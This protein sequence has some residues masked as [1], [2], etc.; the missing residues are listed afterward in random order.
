MEVPHRDSED[1][2][3]KKNKTRNNNT[4]SLQLTRNSVGAKAVISTVGAPQPHRRSTTAAPLEHHSSI[5][6]APSVHCLRIGSRHRG[7]RWM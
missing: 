1:H 7:H 2:K 3:L 5:R 6:K 4:T